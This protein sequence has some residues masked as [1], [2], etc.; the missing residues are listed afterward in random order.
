MTQAWV[1]RALV[2]RSGECQRISIARALL[3]NPRILI[4]DEATASVDVATEQQIQQALGKLT[5]GRTTIAIAHR[6]STL[7]NADRLIVL[8]QGRIVEQGTHTE[9]MAK[10]GVFYDLVQLQQ[11]MDAIIATRE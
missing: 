9:L 1:R 6:L 4:L 2:C 8:D 7:R 10:R 3:H 5:E 11:A